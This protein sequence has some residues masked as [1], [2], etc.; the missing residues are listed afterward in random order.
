MS[1]IVI[2]KLKKLQSRKIAKNDFS[3]T[4]SKTLNEELRKALKK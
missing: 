4:F 3:Y 1:D 2:K